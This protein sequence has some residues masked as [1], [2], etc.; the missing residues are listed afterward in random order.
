MAHS[1]M[2][3]F[4]PICGDLNAVVTIEGDVTRRVR[5]DVRELILQEH[6]RDYHPVG[7]PSARDVK[8][9]IALRKAGAR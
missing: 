3:L 8:E 1:A 5:A 2:K 9:L 4:C 7:Q 6:V